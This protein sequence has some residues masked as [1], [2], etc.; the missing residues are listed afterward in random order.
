[1]L[2]K[3][4]AKE[5]AALALALQ[6]RP[7]RFLS[8]AAQD[9]LKSVGEHLE[10]HEKIVPPET[11]SRNGFSVGDL[12]VCRALDEWAGP[13]TVLTVSGFYGSDVVVKD[14]KR[15][16]VVKPEELMRVV[17]DLPDGAI[18]CSE[19]LPAVSIVGKLQEE[20]AKKNLDLHQGQIVRLRG[21]G[22]RVAFKK[23]VDINCECLVLAVDGGTALI[24]TVDGPVI[25]YI[26]NLE[27]AEDAKA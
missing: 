20:D 5:M 19:W 18:D 12:V 6:E 17:P 22:V 2:I 23:P 25:A 8:A 15:T 14:S 3:M 27:A 24:E 16:F 7:G 4:T 21:N 10:K 13:K 26:N 11:E 9:V 1:M